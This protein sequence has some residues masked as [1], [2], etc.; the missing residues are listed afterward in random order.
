MFEAEN[1]RLAAELVDEELCGVVLSVKH[2]CAYSHLANGKRVDVIPTVAGEVYFVEPNVLLSAPGFG[3]VATAARALSLAAARV[4][5]YN[6]YTLRPT[7]RRDA[8][9]QMTPPTLLGVEFCARVHLRSV[10]DAM[11]QVQP[12][13]DQRGRSVLAGDLRGRRVW[14]DR[15][16]LHTAVKGGGASD[17]K[18]VC[19]A[20]AEEMRDFLVHA[21]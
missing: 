2:L 11:L 21:N 5:S 1:V 6:P 7:E 3:D 4:A 17:T 9:L 15:S 13:R 16:G 19:A 8:V 18:R 12:E 14:V 20:L 10:M